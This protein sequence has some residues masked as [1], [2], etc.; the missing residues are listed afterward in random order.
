M[1]TGK[2]DDRLVGLAS[3]CLSVQLPHKLIDGVR[4]VLHGLTGFF[5]FHAFVCPTIK[6]RHFVQVNFPAIFFASLSE[7]TL[8]FRQEFHERSFNLC[9]VCSVRGRICR[10]VAWR[11]LV[12]HFRFIGRRFCGGIGAGRNDQPNEP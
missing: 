10:A 4:S 6:V 5:A 3:A 8:S 12:S 1:L 9:A 7:L 2:F 11:K